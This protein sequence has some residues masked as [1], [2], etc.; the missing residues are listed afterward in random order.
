M[1]VLVLI[2]AMQIIVLH[3]AGIKLHARISPALNS[4]SLLETAITHDNSPLRPVAV[5]WHPLPA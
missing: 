4:E 2:V 3:M 1:L 5:Y